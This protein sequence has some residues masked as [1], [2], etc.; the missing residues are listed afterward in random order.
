MP[1]ERLTD[2]KIARE[3]GSIQADINHLKDDVRAVNDKLDIILRLEG[4]VSTLETKADDRIYRVE[5]LE[6][7]QAKIVW[8]VIMAV[9]A[10]VLGL[11]IGDKK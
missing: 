4:R 1:N 9:L 10:A 7:N 2:G 6:G 8:A 11:V 3:L 5:K